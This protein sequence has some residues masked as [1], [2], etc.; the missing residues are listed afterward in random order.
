MEASSDVCLP[1]QALWTDGPDSAQAPQGRCSRATAL[2]ASLLCGADGGSRPSLQATHFGARV[3]DEK[4][5]E[6]PEDAHG[7][8]DQVSAVLHPL[9]SD[10]TSVHLDSLPHTVD[11]F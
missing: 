2:E 3:S 4:D 6:I 8:D 9:S 1:N 10:P 5:S 7:E 11:P